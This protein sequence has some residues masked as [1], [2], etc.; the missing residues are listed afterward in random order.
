MLS[1]LRSRTRMERIVIAACFV[2]VVT[3]WV[4]IM[5]RRATHV[6]DFDVSREFGRRFLAREDLYAG[7][8]HYPYM[9]VAA[10]YFSPLALID[11]TVGLAL[12]YGVALGCLWLTLHLLHTMVRK[13]SAAVASHEL[14]IGALS[15]LLASHYIIRDLDDGG[16]HLI[17]L[18]MLV[19]GIYSAWK[20]RDYRAA[21][22]FGLATALKAPAALFV[23]F[24]LWKGR[25]RLAIAT[26]FAASCWIVLPAVW[27]GPSSWWSHQRE[28]AQVVVG[29]LTGNRIAVAEDSELRVQNEAFK[30]V[31]M[32]YLTTY[33]SSTSASAAA[34]VAVLGLI[35]ACGW[36]A[37]RR[38]RAPASP[39]WLLECSAVLILALL[40][41]PVTWV[42]HMV[43]VLPALYLIVAEDRG[44]RRLGVPADSGNGRVRGAC[45]GTQSRVSRQR[46]LRPAAQLRRADPVHAVRAYGH[47]AASSHST[48]RDR[49]KGSTGSLT[50]SYRPYNR[51]WRPHMSGSD[52]KTSQ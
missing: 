35:G 36:W 5:H 18:A 41:S 17:L 1:W 50:S 12:R 47:R 27:M 38:Y 13:R 46:A 7:G 42:Q 25:W 6:G 34:T 39:E 29:S 9:P 21:A 48:Y 14:T 26:V 20:G 33:V 16:P 22:W 51:N 37:R 19:G 30:P 40:V 52:E 23:P 49:Q 32:R 4:V 2:V 43:L 45:V 11:P 15:V 10:M 44:I 28:W 3:Q 31:L 24:F 8:L